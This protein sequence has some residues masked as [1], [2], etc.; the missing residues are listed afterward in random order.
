MANDK[1][2]T[3]LIRGTH[4]EN[5]LQQARKKAMIRQKGVAKFLSCDVRTVQRYEAGVQFPTMSQLMLLRKLFHCE[6]VDLF[7]ADDTSQ[8]CSRLEQNEGDP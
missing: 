3:I 4:P 5:R 6:L 1:T 7:P 8:A 2:S